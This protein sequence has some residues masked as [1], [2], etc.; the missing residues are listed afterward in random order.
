MPSVATNEKVRIVCPAC[1]QRLDV[2]GLDPFTTVGCP[3]CGMKMFVPG[4]EPAVAAAAATPS[5]KHKIACSNCEQR[6]DVTGLTPL[7]PVR[8]PT[9]GMKLIVPPPQ[10]GQ[11]AV[12]VQAQPLTA[13]VRPRAPATTPPA[14]AALPLGQLAALA[15]CAAVAWAGW[16]FRGSIFGS[17]RPDA[18]APAPVA[19]AAPTGLDFWVTADGELAKGEFAGALENYR[20][21]EERLD[22]SPGRLAAVRCQIGA[23]LYLLGGAAEARAAFEG[24]VPPDQRRGLPATVDADNFAAAVAQVVLGVVKPEGAEQRFKDEMPPPLSQMQI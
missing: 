7:T 4:P 14:R 18:A 24:A 1:E 16:H 22:D 19:Q 12:V 15:A 5:P 2:S 8:C 9:C 20:K 11:E 13:A 17:S 3:T 23:T 6:L 10:A 21:A